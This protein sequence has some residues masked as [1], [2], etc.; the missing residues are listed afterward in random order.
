MSA[1]FVDMA[2]GMRG[3]TEQR[4]DLEGELDMARLLIALSAQV[5][6]K[7]K[8]RATEDAYV[9]VVQHRNDKDIQRGVAPA[10]NDARQL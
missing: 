2:D 1:P 5:P 7:H 6:K 10:H 9:D 3:V 8:R 4:S